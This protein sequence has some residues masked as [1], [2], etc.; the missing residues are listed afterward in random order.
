MCNDKS[1][2]F[3]KIIEPKTLKKYVID[4]SRP[5]HKKMLYQN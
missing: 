5:E 4:K 2:D 3:V 1:Q